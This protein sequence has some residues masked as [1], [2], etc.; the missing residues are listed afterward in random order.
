[1]RKYLSVFDA[2][3]NYLSRIVY[4]IKSGWRL[5]ILPNHILKIDSNIYVRIFK[6]FGAF[7]I[8]FMV[9]G[10]SRNYNTIIFYIAAI[11]SLLYI[12]YRFILTFYIIKQYVIHI[13]NGNFIVRNSPPASKT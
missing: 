6:L 3:K 10:I 13:K 8:F 1:M 11:W 4:G 2:N 9:S 7:F 12:L 5:S